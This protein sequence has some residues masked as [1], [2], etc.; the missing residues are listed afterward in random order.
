MT[1]GVVVRRNIDW[2]ALVASGF[3]FHDV[4]MFEPALSLCVLFRLRAT[5]SI[6][7]SKQSVAGRTTPFNSACALPLHPLLLNRLSVLPFPLLDDPQPRK[8][9]GRLHD[10]QDGV[11]YHWSAPSEC[12]PMKIAVRLFTQPLIHRARTDLHA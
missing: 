8:T 1:P 7:V 10:D 11:L 3:T 2:A 6:A 5:Y 9:S 4:A 12:S